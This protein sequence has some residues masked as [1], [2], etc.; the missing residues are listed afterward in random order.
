MH[1]LELREVKK[2]YPGGIEALRG[3]S[4]AVD[5]GEIFGLLGPNGAGKTTAVRILTTLSRATAGTAY[6]AGF[7]V[8][9]QPEEVR[10][11]IGYVAQTTA[12]DLLA[13]GRENLLFHG[14]LFGLGGSRLRSR[15]EEL[16]E[17]F[18]LAEVADRRVQTYSGGMKRRLD[19]AT[20]LLHLPQVLFLDEPT[21]GLDPENRYLLWELVSS[22]ASQ[23]VSQKS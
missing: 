12:L 8:H 20:G 16:I 19:L 15:A 9:D 13:T 5:A 7:E 17:T 6:V 23:R 2:S 4:L 18:Q 10:R 11:Q 14:R 22:L 3:I 1:S 21:S